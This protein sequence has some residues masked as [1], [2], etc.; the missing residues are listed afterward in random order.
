[1]VRFTGCSVTGAAIAASETPRPVL[2]LRPAGAMAGM[3]ADLVL[4]TE[5]LEVVAT[6]VGGEVG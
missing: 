6:I 1:L 4:L 5:D 2:G 3:A